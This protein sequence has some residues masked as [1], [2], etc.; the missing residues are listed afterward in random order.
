MAILFTLDAS[1][2]VA[3]CRPVERD[4]RDAL[5][6]LTALESRAIPL[7]E[8]TLLLV[9]VAAALGRSGT[10]ASLA[11][12]LSQGISQLPQLTL[13]HLDAQLGHHAAVLAATYRL[14]GAEAIYASVALRYGAQLVT[15]DK[16]QAARHPKKLSVLPPAKAL[17]LLRA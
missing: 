1:I 5:A 4:H 3:A 17:A 2:W 9:E 10:R 11:L 12:E 13:V 16:E 14:R 15:L 6:L 7:I 8:P